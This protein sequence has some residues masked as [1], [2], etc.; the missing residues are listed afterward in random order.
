FSFEVDGVAEDQPGVARQLRWSEPKV[1]VAVGLL[2]EELVDGVA[3][4]DGIAREV[5]GTDLG[6]VIPPACVEERLAEGRAFPTPQRIGGADFDAPEALHLLHSREHL[7]KP[8]L[9]LILSEIKMSHFSNLGF[10]SP[11]RARTEQPKRDRDA[12]R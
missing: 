9:Q 7:P 12:E 6:S 3:C 1:D 8:F 2:A 4:E 10:C 5:E 11:A